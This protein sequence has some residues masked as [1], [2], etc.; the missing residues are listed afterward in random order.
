MMISSCLG[1]LL[2]DPLTDERTFV[3]VESLSRLKILNKKYLYLAGGD[4]AVLLA[5]PILYSWL[6][7]AFVL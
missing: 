5:G 3:I 1:V 7:I 6:H 2:Y 4:C